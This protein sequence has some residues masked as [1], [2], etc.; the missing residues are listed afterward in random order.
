MLVYNAAKSSEGH[1]PF[2]SVSQPQIT[3][4]NM[5]EKTLTN[6]LHALQLTTRPRQCL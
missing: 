4:V 5:H 2:V 6:T 3:L 1:V